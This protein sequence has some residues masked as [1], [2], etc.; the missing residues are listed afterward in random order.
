MYP[1]TW[2]AFGVL[3]SIWFDSK[4]DVKRNQSGLESDAKRK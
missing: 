4:S 1:P 2:S 3:N